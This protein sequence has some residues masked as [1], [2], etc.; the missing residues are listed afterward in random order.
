MKVYTYDTDH[1][2]CNDTGTASVIRELCHDRDIYH[3]PVNIHFC[4]ELNNFLKALCTFN[5]LL[6]YFVVMKYCNSICI[7][8]V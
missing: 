8:R 5:C 3:Y 6:L 1:N 4:L 2:N 7:H